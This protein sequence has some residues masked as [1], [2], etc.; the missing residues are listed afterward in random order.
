MAL[1]L[2]LLTTVFPILVRSMVSINI[3]RISEGIAC[4][5]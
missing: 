1:W 5:P 2:F 4:V 3:Y